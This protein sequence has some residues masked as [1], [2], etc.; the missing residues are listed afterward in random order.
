MKNEE[1]KDLVTVPDLKGGLDR[2]VKIKMGQR[3]IVVL[4]ILAVDMPFSHFTAG[5]I[6]RLAAKRGQPHAGSRIWE[7]KLVGKKPF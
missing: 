5:L 1:L 7:R 4:G 3:L 2:S 6:T